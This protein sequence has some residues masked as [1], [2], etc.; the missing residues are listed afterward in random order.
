MTPL[1]PRILLAIHRLA[2]PILDAV[3]VVSH[4]LGS[5]SFLTVLVLAAASMHAVHREWREAATWIAVGL[6]TVGLIDGLKA[7]SARS[8]PELWPRLVEQGGSSFPSG[9]AV[10]AAAFYPL[11]AW[12]LARR[13]PRALP[14]AM[15]V[16][17]VIVLMISVGRLYLGL[18][19]PSDV[20]AGCVI[21]FAESLMAIA[22]IKRGDA[23][24]ADGPGGPSGATS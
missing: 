11:L 17:M 4:T 15:A 22:W 19:W 20:F 23:R 24:G 14:A 7:L 1:E 5:Q 8:R 2:S 12:S 21:G 18:H 13:R 6:A 16:A 3:F 10:A 9:H